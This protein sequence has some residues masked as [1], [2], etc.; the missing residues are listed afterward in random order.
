[1]DFSIITANDRP[2]KKGQKT[3]AISFKTFEYKGAEYWWRLCGSRYGSTVHLQRPATLKQPFPPLV[4]IP[5]YGRPNTNDLEG[6][7]DNYFEQLEFK[8][9]QT[10]E[11]KGII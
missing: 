1:M 11:N 4:K 9:L 5:F 2:Q 7:V 6:L 3:M 10:H 8:G